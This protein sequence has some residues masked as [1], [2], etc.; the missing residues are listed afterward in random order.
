MAERHPSR[1]L[2][3]VPRPDEPDGLDALLSLR[4]FP[5]GDRAVCGEVI[6]LALRGN[7]ASAPASIVLPLLISDLP[8]FCRWR[9]QPRLGLDRVRAARRRSSTG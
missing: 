4:C 8:V 1:T 2:L 7:R 9:G 6:E 3:L 5:I